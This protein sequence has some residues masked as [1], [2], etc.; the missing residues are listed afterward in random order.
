MEDDRKREAD[1]DEREESLGGRSEPN[2]PP[3]DGP[4][5][6]SG[7]ERDDQDLSGS[8]SYDQPEESG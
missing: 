5:A 6:G 1:G 7:G 8:S 2:Q 4:S 3:V